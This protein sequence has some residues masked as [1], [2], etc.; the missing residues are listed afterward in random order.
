MSKTQYDIKRD[1]YE[2][3]SMALFL[4]QFITSNQI[5]Y[6]TPHQNLEQM[7]MMTLG[8]FLMRLRRLAAL[9][10]QLD[11]GS[12]AQLS[13]AVQTHEAVMK[14]WSVHYR[15]KLQ[16][17]LQTRLNSL[18]N[19]LD[20][21]NESSPDYEHDLL[22]ELLARTAIEELLTQ[23]RALDD[24]DNELLGAI[25]SIDRKWETLTHES[26]FHWDEQLR[27]VYPRTAYRWLYTEL[28]LEVLSS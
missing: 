6:N 4:Q 27:G 3:T 21:L 19:F 9:Q 8:T 28:N 10:S 12:R 1:L 17:E 14:D 7:P 24:V 13:A 18:T 15:I 20:N 26:Y 23:A 11:I 22:P 5:F 25:E 2:L 16:G